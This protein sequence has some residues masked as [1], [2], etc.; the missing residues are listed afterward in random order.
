MEKHLFK[1]HLA[2]SLTTPEMKSSQIRLAVLKHCE[3]A[4]FISS[5]DQEENSQ[6]YQWLQEV[7]TLNLLS[8]NLLDQIA[9]GESGCSGLNELQIEI[10]AKAASIIKDIARRLIETPVYNREQ[11]DV[12][13]AGQVGQRNKMKQ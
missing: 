6:R 13:V 2:K 1:Q 11:G 4:G 7:L 3:N 8:L 9:L 10:N 5:K 12:Q